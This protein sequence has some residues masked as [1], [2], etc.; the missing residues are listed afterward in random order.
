[1][2]TSF[3]VQSGPFS[4]PMDLGLPRPFPECGKNLIRKVLGSSQTRDRVNILCSAHTEFQSLNL[5]LGC[6]TSDLQFFQLH[7][8]WGLCVHLCDG[9]RSQVFEET[10]LLD[11]NRLVAI[12]F[13]SGH[14]VKLP[15]TWEHLVVILV[16]DAEFTCFLNYA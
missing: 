16:Y 15:Q 13:M 6:S 3:F 11:F 5:S 14:F 9:V 10:A 7:F 2:V 8:R 4:V 12:K 1:M